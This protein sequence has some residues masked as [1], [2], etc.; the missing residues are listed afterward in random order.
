MAKRTLVLFIGLIFVAG[1]VFAGGQQEQQVKIG[2]IGPLTGDYANYGNL[3]SQAVQMA[4][5]E[6]NEAGGIGGNEIVLISE[7]SEADVARGNAAIEKLASVD[8]IDGLVGGVFSTVSLAIAPRAQTEQIVMISGSATH[9]DL[10]ANGDYVF[11]TI[12]SDALQGRVFGQYVYEELGYEDVAILYTRNDYSQGLTNVFTETFEGAGG[13]VVAT[14][15]GI[16]GDRDFRTQLTTIR[17]ENPD[18]IFLPNYVAEIAQVLEQAEQLGIDAAMLS[19]DGFSNPEIFDLAGP[20]TNSVV[21]S[22]PPAEGGGARERAEAFEEKY[23]ETYGVGPDSFSYNAYDAA[24]IILDA[25]QHAY[26][27]AGA[28][29]QAALDLDKATIR[30]YVAGIQG[31]SGVSGTITFADSG[32][33]VKNIGIFEVQNQQFEQTG[34]YTVVDG[35]LQAQ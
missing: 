11:R 7:D 24:N 26:D 18:A 3:Q 30:D 21:F 22:G 35:Q 2:F 8:Q 28:D 16:Q 14:E 12:A 9:P 5:D 33:V 10:T 29:A 31:Y 19:A 20:L 32:D 1:L 23:T 27:Q 4:I 17:A 15:S 25:I 6:R 34:V 13:E